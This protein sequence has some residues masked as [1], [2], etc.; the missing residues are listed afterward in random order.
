MAI[1]REQQQALETSGWTAD[2]VLER[3]K[4]AQL[5]DAARTFTGADLDALRAHQRRSRGLIPEVLLGFRP[6]VDMSAVVAHI[7]RG[8]AG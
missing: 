3:W 6:E 8:E 7:E 1:A 4:G 5:W 2:R